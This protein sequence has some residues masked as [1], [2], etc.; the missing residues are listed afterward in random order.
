MDQRAA[1]PRSNALNTRVSLNLTNTADRYFARGDTNPS[2]G[3]LSEARTAVAQTP[4]SGPEMTGRSNRVGRTFDTPS[5]PD[6]GR[7]YV[8]TLG[9]VARLAR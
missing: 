1:G 3:P 7:A 2:T 6:P 5:E 9:T 4:R 8:A